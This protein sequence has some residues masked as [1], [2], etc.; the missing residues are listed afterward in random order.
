MKFKNIFHKVLIATFFII[1][2]FSAKVHA[3]SVKNTIHPV[4]N[5]EKYENWENLDDK[6]KVNTISP[7]R[8]TINY[9]SSIY[10]R[11]RTNALFSARLRASYLTKYDLRD[12]ITITVRDQGGTSECWAISTNSMIETNIEKTD[13]TISPRFSSRYAEYATAKTFLDGINKNAYNRE[14]GQGGTAQIALGL[15]TSGRGPVLESSMPFESNT[16]KINLSKIENLEVQKKIEEYV[17]FPT[18]YKRYNNNGKITYYNDEY[19]FSEM[20]IQEIR[21]QIKEHIV[22]YGAITAQTYGVGYKELAREYYSNPLNPMAS[23][24][25]FCN[26][27]N[28]MPDHQVTIIGWDD[29]YDISNFTAQHRPSSPGAYIVLNSWGEEFGDNGIYYISY[30]D[31]LIESYL[32]GTIKTS[33]IDYDNLYQHDELGVNYS[34]YSTS[35]IYGANVFTRKDTTKVEEL[36]EI[37]VSSLANFKCDVYV[38]KDGDLS[39]NKLIKINKNTLDLKCGY[40]TIKL[41][42]PVYLSNDKFAIVV[43]YI[44]DDTGIVYLGLESQTDYKWNTAKSQRGQSYL[45]LDLQEWDDLCDLAGETVVPKQSNLCIK[46]FTTEA[47]E[48]FVVN[49][50]EKGDNYIYVN[51]REVKVNEFIPKIYTNM[52]YEII[53]KNNNKLNQNSLISTGAKVKTNSKEYS[54]VVLGDLNGDGK[55]TL[56]DLVKMKLYD[57]NLIKLEDVYKKAADVNR[58]GK[59]TTTDLVQ[60]NLVVAGIRKNFGG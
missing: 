37:S 39:E 18:I 25:Y 2:A 10:N 19:E 53:G 59:V 33:D 45:S 38:S 17:Y 44:L 60:L 8:Y 5:T 55:V 27:P 23:K 58:N 36:T 40:H 4:E 52:E 22:K 50:Y 41:E 30:E 29:N 21:K 34:I 6:D 43:K 7:N 56:T 48:Y 13:N 16:N 14:V 57:V 54:I 20:E 26:N 3:V 35:E 42:E 47:Q 28:V 24:A 1:F 9:N 51:A 32:V 15:Y 11:D 12:D 49:D 46:A 31:C